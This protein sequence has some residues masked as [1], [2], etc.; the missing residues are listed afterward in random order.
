[1]GYYIK[2][3]D[4]FVSDQ[5]KLRVQ[6]SYARYINHPS[7]CRKTIDRM[8]DKGIE[9]EYKIFKWQSEEDVTEYVLSGA[10]PELRSP[11]WR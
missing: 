1:M 8:K 11:H 7:E 2:V 9:G 4:M 10:R 3:N 6:R 5:H